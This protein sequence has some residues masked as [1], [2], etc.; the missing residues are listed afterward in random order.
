MFFAMR[1]TG[2]GLS[3]V[4]KLTNI[5]NLHCPVTHK[6]W[7]KHTK[8]VL[9]ISKSLLEGNLLE[10]ALNCKIFLQNTGQI[11]RFES[12]E[13]RGE[14]V[15]IG[16]TL[17]GSWKTRGWTPRDTIVDVCFH[18]TGKYYMW[19]IRRPSAQMWYLKKKKNLK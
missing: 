8:K 18:Q 4:E 1:C 14:I 6:Y 3:A 13:L 2:K 16:V 17:D 7:G 12:T 5:F 9:D 11:Y 19:Y 15:N 10:Q